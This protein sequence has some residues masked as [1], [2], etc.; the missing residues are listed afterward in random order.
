MFP[1]RTSISFKFWSFLFA[2][3][4]CVSSLLSLASAGRVNVTID[5]TLGDELTG[6]LIS[7]TPQG[8][9]KLGQ[10]CTDCTAHPDASRAHKGSWHDGTFRNPQLSTLTPELTAT[11]SFDGVAVYVY[12][13]TTG[14]SSSLDSSALLSFFIDDALVGHYVHA[15]N[16]D[17]AYQY[18]VP[19]FVSGPLPAGQHVLKIVNGASSVKKSLVLLDYVVYTCVARR[20]Q[21]RE[22]WGG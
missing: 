12:G 9:W 7:Y 5:D 14:T 11:V 20:E 2:I 18:D 13:I 4:F 22:L 21:V 10:S 16:G 6:Q 19:L 15:P 3:L 1:R 17:S 8:A